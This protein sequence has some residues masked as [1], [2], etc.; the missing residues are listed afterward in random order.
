MWNPKRNDTQMKLLT[1]QRL[2]DLENEFMVAGRT[3]GE[4]IVREFGW[5][6]THCSI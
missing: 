3:M 2:T 1:K 5:I 4:G 6:C